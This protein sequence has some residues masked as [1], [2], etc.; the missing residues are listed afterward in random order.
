MTANL[1]DDGDLQRL[2]REEQL[3]EQAPRVLPEDNRVPPE[4]DLSILAVAGREEESKFDFSEM[5]DGILAALKE[6]L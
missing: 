1:F 3:T 5:L 2:T 6:R 4:D